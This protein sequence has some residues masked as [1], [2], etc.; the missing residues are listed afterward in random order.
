MN[1]SKAVHCFYEAYIDF[2]RKY[3]EQ[4]VQDI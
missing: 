1:S 2:N 4:Q 3:P